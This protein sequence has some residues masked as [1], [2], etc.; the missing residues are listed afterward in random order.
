MRGMFGL[1][2]LH[3]SSLRSVALQSSRLAVPRTTILLPCPKRQSIPLTLAISARGM[4]G[5]RKFIIQPTR[6]VFRRFQKDATFFIQI[7]VIPLTLITLYFN[8]WVGPGTLTEIPEG[9]VPEEWEYYKNPVT[10]F[11]AR[12]IQDYPQKGYEQMLQSMYEEVEII[13]LRRLTVKVKALQGERMDYQGYT[14]IRGP[15]TKY[16]EKHREQNDRF[17]EEVVDPFHTQL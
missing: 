11:I 3:V 10:S 1:Q 4:S 8:V 17:V 16:H 15:T 6:F 14:Y 7:A 12:Y 2:S 9:Y 13:R 5:T